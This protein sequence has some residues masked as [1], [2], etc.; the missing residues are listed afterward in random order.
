[1]FQLP[2]NKQHKQNKQHKKYERLQSAFIYQN[3]NISFAI[4]FGTPLSMSQSWDDDEHNDHSGYGD[5]VVENAKPKIKRPSQHKVMLLNDDYTPMEFVVY[6]LEHF[7]SM[8]RQQATQTMLKV[9]TEG[10]ATCGI[11]PLDIAETKA[12]QV[13]QCALENEH[14]LKCEVE[15]D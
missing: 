15:S 3:Q 12:Q 6:V 8:D 13:E 2:L 11:F 10:R 14:P 7:F 1:M 4:P 5:L 9:H